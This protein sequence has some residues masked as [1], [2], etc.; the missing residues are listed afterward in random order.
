MCDHEVLRFNGDIMRKA[1]L[2]GGLTETKMVC[3]SHLVMISNGVVFFKVYN[4][5]VYCQV[6]VLHFSELDLPFLMF[7]VVG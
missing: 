2:K 3:S 4:G 1:C 5:S 6:N 7:I